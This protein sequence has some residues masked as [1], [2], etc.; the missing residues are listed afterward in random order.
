MYST[1]VLLTFVN[2]TKASDRLAGISNLGQRYRQG[3]GIGLGEFSSNNTR[4]RTL[5]T[6]RTNDLNR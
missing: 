6:A 4:H 2:D 3:Q 5:V 1:L